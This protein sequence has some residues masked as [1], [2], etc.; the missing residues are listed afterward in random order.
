MLGDALLP[1]HPDIILHIM[2]THFVY[3]TALNDCLYI[4]FLFSSVCWRSIG[5][6]KNKNKLLSYQRQLSEEI[7]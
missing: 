7:V 6:F 5:F 4:L 1:R 2:F 3:L